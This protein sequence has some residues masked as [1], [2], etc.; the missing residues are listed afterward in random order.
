MTD[1]NAVLQIKLY[2][3]RLTKRGAI[4]SYEGH[5]NSHTR[6]QL[7]IDPFERFVMSGLRGCIFSS[8]CGKTEAYLNVQHQMRQSYID[9]YPF[10]LTRTDSTQPKICLID[11]GSV[12]LKRLIFPSNKI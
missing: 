12:F 3:H 8:S 5:V 6:V 4:Q 7:G 10:Q 11:I 9:L 2:D 1:L